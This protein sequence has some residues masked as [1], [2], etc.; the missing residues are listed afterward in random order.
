MIT[1]L[2][3]YE[4]TPMLYALT[5]GQLDSI[6][7]HLISGIGYTPAELIGDECWTGFRKEAEREFELCI[8]HFAAHPD[9]MLIDLKNGTFTRA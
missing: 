6:D 8:K 4:V 5:A 1:V 7:S 2:G 3:K 9:A